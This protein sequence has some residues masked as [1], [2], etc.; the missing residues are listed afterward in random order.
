MN[1]AVCFY[2]VCAFWKSGFSQFFFTAQFGFYLFQ[3]VTL[4]SFTLRSLPF[5]AVKAERREGW[6]TIV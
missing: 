5:V 3:E 4:D 6:E 1:G 2:S